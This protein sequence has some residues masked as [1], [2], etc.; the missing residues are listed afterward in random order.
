MDNEVLAEVEE[1]IDTLSKGLAQYEKAL[2]AGLRIDPEILNNIYRA[3]HTL[4]GLAGMFGQEKMGKLVH[5]MEN[6]L[7]LMRLGKV[8]VGQDMLDILFEAVEQLEKILASKSPDS[9][10]LEELL[11]RLNQAAETKPAQ[12]K[13]QAKEF[14]I[15]EEILR[16]LT[17]AEEYRLKVNLEAGLNVV[18]VKAVF[19]QANFDTQLVT[20]RDWLKKY[21][22]VIALLP[23][24]GSQQQENN[25]ISFQIIYATE[26]D[27]DKLIRALNKNNRNLKLEVLKRKNA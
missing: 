12:A 15:P 25:V 5:A 11:Q 1:H 23:F 19:P 9:L 21:G 6:L 16:I 13:Q 26:G 8:L 14:E 4:K 17:E 18:I 22:E 27:L 3:A 2:K 20:L 10:N 24:S 7:S